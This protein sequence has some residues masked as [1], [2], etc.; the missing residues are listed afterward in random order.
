MSMQADVTYLAGGL[1]GLIL[2]RPDRA[3]FIYGGIAGR[4]T[5]A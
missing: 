2:S 5:A 1:P 3:V 4:S